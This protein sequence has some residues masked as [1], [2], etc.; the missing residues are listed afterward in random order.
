MSSSTVKHHGLKANFIFN[1][2]SQILTLIVPLITTPYVWNVLLAEGN[3]QYSYSLS[4]ITYFILFAGMG[5]DLYG[6]KQVAACREDKE[7][8]S[9]LFW[10]IFLL[11]SIF[12]ALSMG[13]LLGILY[14]VGFGE[15]YDILILI[16][17]I[18]VIAVPFDIQF[19]FRG[20]EDFLAIAIRSI[21]MRVVGMVCIFVFV[22]RSDQVWLYT[23]CLSVL[24]IASALIMWPSAF[25]RI[26]FVSPKKLS[27]SRHIVPSL[28]IF[29][30]TLAVT[31]YS[32]FDKTMIGLLAEN[33]DVEN[34]YYEKAYQI[35][36][37]ALLLVT[38]ISSVMVSRN[39]YD[40]SE[41]NY[42]RV[43][44]HLYAAS[45]YVWM[46][47]L[48]LIVGFSVLSHNLCTWFFRKEYEGIPILLMIMSVRFVVSG[49]GEVLGNQLFIAIGK[50]QYPLIATIG[51]AVINFTLNFFLIPIYGAMGAAI[52]TAVCEV[53]NTATLFIIAG[54][55]KYVSPLKI[56]ASSW[57]YIL[58]AGIMFVPIFFLQ[59]AMGETVWTF[60]L[61]TF[62]G[63]AVYALSLAL[64]RDVFFLKY[65]KIALRTV[66]RILK[67]GGKAAP[68]V[69]EEEEKE[70]DHTEGEASPAPAEE[71]REQENLTQ[72]IRPS[73]GSTEE[74]K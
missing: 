32:V 56:I 74:S 69:A 33:A 31:V 36:S 51:A 41:G 55:K 7:K 73:D 23:L 11:K 35:N 17:S 19:L 37:V 29:L 58:S 8:K 47:G 4:I 49:F 40:Y 9:V 39:S 14:G 30:P 59:R 24:C 18:Q 67:R 28:L 53:V 61:I 62:T 3:G 57:K 64:L 46:M 26:A 15:K 16:L 10:E 2:V 50:N 6:Q 25:R 5:F 70:A 20:D 63:M 43:R 54:V 12:T 34:G 44:E 13:V 66:G 48:P 42:E 38:I 72:D 68:A 1:F 22:K 21:F 45:R 27:L 71:T 52:A 60:L 65:V